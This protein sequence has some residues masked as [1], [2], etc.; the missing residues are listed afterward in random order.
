MSN[1]RTVGSVEYSF[2]LNFS[3]PA[4]PIIAQYFNFVHLG[5]KGYRDVALADLKNARTLSRALEASGYFTVLSDIHRPA[6]PEPGALQKAVQ[7][8]K[9]TDVEVNWILRLYYLLRLKLTR[10]SKDY[11]PGL[12]VVSF[13]F[14][15]EFKVNDVVY[16]VEA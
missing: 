14:T 5:F 16:F 10:P 4:H 11:Q 9:S 8:F 1:I 15:D 3:R 7:T 6:N 12:P 13:R 2:S